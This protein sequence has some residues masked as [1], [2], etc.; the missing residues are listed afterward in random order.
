M[1]VPLKVPDAAGARDGLAKLIYS[2]LFN[3]ILSRINQGL[4]PSGGVRRSTF[5]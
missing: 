4:A 5:H 1:D 3:W 2:A